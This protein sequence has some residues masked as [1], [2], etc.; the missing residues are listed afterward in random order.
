MKYLGLLSS[1][2]SGKMG[3]IVASHNRG[4]SYFRSH[5]VPVQPRTPAQTLNRNQLAAFSAAFKSLTAAQV[6]GWNSLGSTV[7]L[8]DALGN[9]FNP[10]GQQLFVSCNRH[11]ASLGINTQLSTAPSIPSVPGFTTFT[12]APTYTSGLITA[13]ALSFTPALPSNF[14][15]LLRATG[16]Q[17]QGRTFLGKSAFRTLAG[18]NPA[19]GL[20]TSLTTVYTNVFG[21][22]PGQGFV[23]FE[24]KM[25]DPVSG[26]AGPAIR[27][28]CQFASTATTDL[29]TLATGAQ[30]GTTTAGSGAVTF[31]ITPTAIGGFAGAVTYEVTGLP[32]GCT[33]AFNH[34]PYAVASAPT[35]T[36]TAASTTAGTYHP[37]VIGSYGTY[38]TNVT[39]TLTIA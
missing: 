2:A 5:V 29:F 9:S 38:S 15:V 35:L 39:L 4:G 10:T 34:N 28:T 18:Y 1:A 32:T 24:L 11:L 25:I 3:G 12:A 19:T 33:F 13:F 27:A 8:K 20:P 16:A 36:V 17:S 26:F 14:G 30:G 22:F 7:T 31:T 6:A 23:G 37:T 21:P